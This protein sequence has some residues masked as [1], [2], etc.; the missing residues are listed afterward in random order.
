VR[1]AEELRALRRAKNI[2]DAS[3]KQVYISLSILLF[4]LCEMQ[5]SAKSWSSKR[6]KKKDMHQAWSVLQANTK[7]QK[8]VVFNF[9]P[10]RSCK[11][12]EFCRMM[13]LSITSLPEFS[14]DY[15]FAHVEPQFG[16][17]HE[18][19]PG[20]YFIY[21]PPRHKIT[22]FFLCLR[23]ELESEILHDDAELVSPST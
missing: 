10:E 2:Q 8:L 12:L 23:V 14:R 22:I 4:L 1:T 15:F 18:V 13:R 7:K 21:R 19:G 16:M 17:F 5:W 11:S 6:V 20:R 3:L 9:C